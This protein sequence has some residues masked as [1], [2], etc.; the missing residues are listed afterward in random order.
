MGAFCVSLAK[1]LSLTPLTSLTSLTSKKQDM[2]NRIVVKVGSNVL[3]RDDGKLDITHVSA[4]V[5]QLA[6]LRG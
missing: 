3:T 5:D 1:H 6:W 2:P 4:L